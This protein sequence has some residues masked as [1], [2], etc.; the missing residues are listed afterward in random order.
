MATIARQGIVN[1]SHNRGGRIM[2]FIEWT[3]DLSVHI[4]SVDA[5]HKNLVAIINRLYDS[6]QAGKANA[7]MRRIFVE[8]AEY[9]AS[10]FSYEERLFKQHSYPEMTSHQ[11]SHANLI[12]QMKELQK[13]LEAGIPVSIKTF[14]FLKK[15][16]TEHIM[17]EDHRYS[18][19]LRA[20]GVR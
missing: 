15:W 2:S 1:P 5:Q 10:H 14:S 6:M 11:H 3:D 8:L 17:K 18:G 7:I 12:V 16:L 20:K 4:D 19:F 13:K 9:T